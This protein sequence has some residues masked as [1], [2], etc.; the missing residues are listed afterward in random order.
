MTEGSSDGSESRREPRHVVQ[1][2]GNY[3]ARNRGGG[4]KD[5]W[6]KDIS[7]TGCRFFD[8]FSI[9]EVGSSILFRVG[10]VGPI[11]AQVRWREKNVVGIQFDQPLYPSVL[12]HIVA[13]MNIG[14]ADAD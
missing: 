10:N 12:E 8:K 5:I 7:E 1:V 3:R 13:T 2:A 9:L 11:S 4:T 6:I 14:Q